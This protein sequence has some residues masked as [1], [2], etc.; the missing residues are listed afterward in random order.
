M[1]KITVNKLGL[2][3]PVRV[4]Y[5]TLQTVEYPN[6]YGNELKMFC[7]I[8]KGE[9]VWL[10]DYGLPELVHKLIP[11]NEELQAIILANIRAYF[12]DG[13]FN[14]TCRDDST[15]PPGTKICNLNYRISNEIGVVEIEL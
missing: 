3:Y 2:R 10:K 11:N 14:I 8:V 6:K 15:R 13:Q 12:P 9:R 4:E 1:A 5:G 7:S